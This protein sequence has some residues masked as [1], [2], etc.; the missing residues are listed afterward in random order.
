MARVLDLGS[1]SCGFESHLS[2][3]LLRVGLEI[4]PAW[5]HKPN[6]ESAILSPATIS[7]SS[8]SVG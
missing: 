5:S 1:R 7:L 6:E 2:D 4:D 8:I 3:H